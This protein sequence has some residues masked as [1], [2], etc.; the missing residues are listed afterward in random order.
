MWR[1]LQL[2]FLR[3]FCSTICV[4]KFSARSTFSILCTFFFHFSTVRVCI[5]TLYCTC[6]QLYTFLW[7]FL[8]RLFTLPSFPSCFPFGVELCKNETTQIKVCG[9]IPGSAI[10]LSEAVSSHFLSPS[11]EREGGE[12]CTP[13]QWLVLMQGLSC[14]HPQLQTVA[15]R[16]SLWE[17]DARIWV[18]KVCMAQLSSPSTVLIPCQFFKVWHCKATC[19]GCGALGTC[20]EPRQIRKCNVH[21]VLHVVLIWSCGWNFCAFV[22]LLQWLILTSLLQSSTVILEFDVGNK[23]FAN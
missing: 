12:C 7:Q 6:P 19:L 2:T 1:C 11:R 23:K 21:P 8:Y 14:M 10:S 3:R 16:S 15:V 22:H 17:H 5:V 18:V 4:N 9:W 20:R 13:P